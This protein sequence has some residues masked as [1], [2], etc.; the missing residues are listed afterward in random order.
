MCLEQS[1]CMANLRHVNVIHVSLLHASDPTWASTNWGIVLCIEC[2]GIH[3]YVET[4]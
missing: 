2:S 4:A 1:N 3:R